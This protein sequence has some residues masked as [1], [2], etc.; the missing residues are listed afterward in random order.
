MSQRVIIIEDEHEITNIIC[1]ILESRNYE[2]VCCHTIGTFRQEVARKTPDLMILDVMLP[3]GNGAELCYEMKNHHVFRTIPILLMSAH[4]G[5]KRLS[6]SCAD[7]FIEKP[8]NIL[9]LRNKVER[10]LAGH[11]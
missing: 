7:A 11:L 4:L 2:L 5:T 10:L 1:L 3:D 6:K 9:D 8:F